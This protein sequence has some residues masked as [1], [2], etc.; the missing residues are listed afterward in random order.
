MCIFNSPMRGKEKE[1][2]ERPNEIDIFVYCVVGFHP[3]LHRIDNI[4]RNSY[5]S[6]KWKQRN[7]RD[8]VANIG[9]KSLHIAR[10]VQCEC[11]CVRDLQMQIKH[12]INENRKFCGH[13][14]RRLDV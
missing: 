7:V 10:H 4:R 8:M 3:E 5:D 14:H 6:M 11:V 1:I 2:K 12:I 13:N 9:K